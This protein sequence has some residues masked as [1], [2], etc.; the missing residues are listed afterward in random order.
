MSR[1]VR[2]KARKSVLLWLKLVY[3]LYVDGETARGVEATRT[4]IAL[5]MLR[6]LVL[7]QHCRNISEGMNI[8]SGKLSPF[9]SSNSLSQYQHH[10]RRIYKGLRTRASLTICMHT[11]LFFFLA[12]EKELQTRGERRRRAEGRREHGRGRGRRERGRQTREVCT[13]G[14]RSANYLSGRP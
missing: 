4:E 5:E 13:A 1:Q 7:H 11:C 9:S 12:I 14:F 3:L 6:F 8:Y 2:K 10:G